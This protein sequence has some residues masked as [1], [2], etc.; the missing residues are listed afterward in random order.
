MGTELDVIYGI[1]KKYDLLWKSIYWDV[2]LFI[3]TKKRVIS[4]IL[5]TWENLRIASF[6]TLLT[7]NMF[8]S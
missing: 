2:E 4:E 1:F 7:M 8:F 5:Q 3:E 6:G